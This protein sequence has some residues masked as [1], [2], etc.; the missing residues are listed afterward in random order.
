[1]NNELLLEIKAQVSDVTSKINQLKSGLSETGNVIDT[2]NSKAS[3][4]KK[5][6]NFGAIALTT[7]KIGQTFMGF[8]DATNDY[9]ESMNLF[10]V[11]LGNTEDKLSKIGQKGLKFQKDMNEAFGTQMSQNLTYQGLYQS[12]AENMGIVEDKA[13]IMSENTTKLINDLSSLYNKSERTTAE[14]LRAGIYAGQTKPLRSFGLDV[15]ERSLQP[16]LDRIGVK[17]DDGT[18]QTVRNL[19]LA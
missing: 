19:S 1:M 13:Y 5:A 4:I 17:A 7:K 16:V 12:M 10:N 15:T 6:F 2:V 8:V 3:N 11:V 14:A 9:A 18:N